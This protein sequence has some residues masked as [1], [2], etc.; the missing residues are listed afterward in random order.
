M[1][2]INIIYALI[3]MLTLT[4]YTLKQE[5]KT[6]WMM[7]DST[8]A[9][10]DT[11]KFP[12]TGWGMPFATLFHA[13]ISVKNEAQNGRSTRSFINEGRWEEIYRQL[14][15]GDYLL[16]QFGHNDEKVN[17][18]KVGTSLAEYKR[19]LSLFVTKA[20]EKKAHPILLTPIAR[21]AFENGKLVETHQGYPNAMRSVADSLQVPLID[22]TQKTNDLLA[23]LGEEKSK[24]LFLHV[25]PGHQNYPK[26]VEDNTHLNPQGALTI[27]KLAANGIRELKLELKNDLK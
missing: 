13:N 7:G 8:M 26:G 6:V 1:K 10:K 11:A 15:A 25:K 23:K 2:Q 4:A 19:N 17:K 21:R 16:I 14:A 3:G 5:R 22:L 20:L 27:A 24:K 9:I 18:P 12:E